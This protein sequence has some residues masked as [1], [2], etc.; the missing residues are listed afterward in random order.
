GWLSPFPDSWTWQ[1]YLPAAGLLALGIYLAINT[2][3]EMHG[4]ARIQLAVVTLLALGIGALCLVPL[5]AHV[6][7]GP[8][9]FVTKVAAFLFFYVWARGTLPRFRYDQLM[10]FG[11]KLLLPVSLANLV[12]TALWLVRHGLVIHG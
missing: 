7:Q 3:T 2:V 6:I 10:S 11:W 8:F 4:I 5:V 1:Y 9:W 12:L